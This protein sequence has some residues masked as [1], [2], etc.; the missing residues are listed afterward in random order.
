[1]SATD[2]ACS[3]SHLPAGD[4]DHQLNDIAETKNASKGL[5]KPGEIEAETGSCEGL[6]TVH[7]LSLSSHAAAIQTS[8]RPL[9]YAGN[10]LWQLKY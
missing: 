1:M 6:M 2:Q 7:V 9:E 8:Q 5:G 4:G 3:C 10:F